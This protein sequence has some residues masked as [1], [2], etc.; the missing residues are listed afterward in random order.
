MEDLK[1][2]M[3]LYDV[4]LWLALVCQPKKIV[5]EAKVLAYQHPEL[6]GRM[7][8]KYDLTLEQ[9]EDAFF[10]LKR[11][12]LKAAET[13]ASPPSEL[14]DECWHHFMLFSQGASIPRIFAP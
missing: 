4:F 12:L 5:E 13:K 10:H 14:V 1:M 7:M 9:A 8:E 3:V 2:R 11:Y 6:I